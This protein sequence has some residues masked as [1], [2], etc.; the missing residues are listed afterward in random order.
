[1]TSVP[2]VIAAAVDRTP[3][4]VGSEPVQSSAGGGG[5]IARLVI[6]LVVVVGAIWALRWVLEQVRA[7]REGHA[8]GAGLSALSSL[9]LGPNRS[10]HLVRAGHELVL[11]GVA[12]QGVTPIRTY[13]EDEARAAGLLG[14][15]GEPGAAAATSLLAGLRERT[16]RR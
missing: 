2:L 6:G 11:L 3:I 5:G 14:A 15:D 4:D 1:V 9:P 13:T 8:P 10:V 12:E 7:S 16:V